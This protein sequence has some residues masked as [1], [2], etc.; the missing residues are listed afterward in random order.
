ML[1]TVSGEDKARLARDN[2]C[3]LPIISR[4]YRFARAVQDAT[5]GRGVD[6]IYDGLGRAGIAV[7]LQLLSP[8]ADSDAEPAGAMRRTLP[9][10]LVE[11]D[12]TSVPAAPAP[13]SGP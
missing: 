9:V 1:G 7:L 13:G 3:E 4:D 10:R 6:V 11:R 8:D 5:S 2:G 12:S